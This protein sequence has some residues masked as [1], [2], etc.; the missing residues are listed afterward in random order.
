MR[1]CHS[2]GSGG[3]A[4]Q[5]VELTAIDMHGAAEAPA[6]L[7]AQLDD[8]VAGEPRRDPLK[9]RDFPELA[10]VG[11]TNLLWDKR[12]RP[13]RHADAGHGFFAGPRSASLISLISAPTPIVLATGIAPIGVIKIAGNE[14]GIAVGAKFRP[15]VRLRCARDS[16]RQLRYGRALRGDRIETG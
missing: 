7:K 14:L 13:H 3:I 1:G 8:G 2:P 9:I 11:P 10:A 12:D 16:A 5:G 15:R 4:A 6:D